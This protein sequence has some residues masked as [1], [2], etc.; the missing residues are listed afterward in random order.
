MACKACVE[1]KVNQIIKITAEIIAV[2]KSFQYSETDA[3][4]LVEIMSEKCPE[5]PK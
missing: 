5:C 4:R 1:N 2:N 3:E